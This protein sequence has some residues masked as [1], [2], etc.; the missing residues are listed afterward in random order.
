MTCFHI[1]AFKQQKKHCMTRLFYNH[2][3]KFIPTM[4]TIKVTVKKPGAC[5]MNTS[6]CNLTSNT[7]DNICYKNINF[8]TG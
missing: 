1:Y 7:E 3:Q 5:S 4:I 2:I 6:Y 8:A